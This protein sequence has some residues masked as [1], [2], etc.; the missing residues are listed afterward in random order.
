MEPLRDLIQQLDFVERELKQV[1]AEQKLRDNPRPPREKIPGLDLNGFNLAHPDTRSQLLDGPVILEK[2]TAEE[3]FARLIKNLRIQIKAAKVYLQ[4][5]AYPYAK[6]RVERIT[7]F[8]AALKRLEDLSGAAEVEVGYYV[9]QTLFPDNLQEY[10]WDCASKLISQTRTGLIF[11]CFLLS[12]R[13]PKYA[14]T[15]WK[16]CDREDWWELQ[17]FYVRPYRYH[18]D[19]S[20]GPRTCGCCSTL[21]N[22]SLTPYGVD[23]EVDHFLDYEGEMGGRQWYQLHAVFEGAGEQEYPNYLADKL[24]KLIARYKINSPRSSVMEET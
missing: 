16:M 6:A 21:L 5:D 19:D 18:Y 22:Y 17:S 9:S 15:L 24:E 3:R 10:C 1:D 11:T 12:R 20:G 8:E 2:I 13:F 7:Q 4:H 14:Y 23:E